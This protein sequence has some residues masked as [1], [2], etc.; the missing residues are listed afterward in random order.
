MT[1][2]VTETRVFISPDITS[3]LRNM[4]KSLGF[5]TASNVIVESVEVQDEVDSVVEDPNIIDLDVNDD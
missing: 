2:P 5:K 3:S 4:T 1:A